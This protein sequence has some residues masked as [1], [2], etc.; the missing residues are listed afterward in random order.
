[1]IKP[2]ARSCGTLQ[3]RLLHDLQPS[4]ALLMPMRAAGLT[5]VLYPLL[6]SYELILNVL[7]L[8][9]F[10]RRKLVRISAR[11]LTGLMPSWQ[12]ANCRAHSFALTYAGNSI[13]KRIRLQPGGQVLRLCTK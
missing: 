1:M 2:P 11:L 13:G 4:D 9:A 12:F 5:V 8:G 3:H 6:E 10:G 7:T